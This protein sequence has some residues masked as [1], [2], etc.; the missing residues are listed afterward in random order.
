[1]RGHGLED[2]AVRYP[3]E[4][5]PKC[6]K[7]PPGWGY[8]TPVSPSEG[9]LPPLALPRPGAG[10]GCNRRADLHPLRRLRAGL[11]PGA[12]EAPR[13]SMRRACGAGLLT[14][15]LVRA[16]LYG[17]RDATCASRQQDLRRQGGVFTPGLATQPARRPAPPASA[18]R[19]YPTQTTVAL[20]V[21]VS[22]PH[23]T[24]ARRSCSAWAGCATGAQ[25]C[26]PC[27]GCAPVAVLQSSTRNCTNAS[28]DAPVLQDASPSPGDNRR[29]D[30]HPLRRLRAGLPPDDCHL[31]WSS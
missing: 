12:V 22:H 11:P 23:C 13:S 29:A 5:E 17:L 27:V 8:A 28:G 7:D 6:R 9:L 21:S 31:S 1:M 25:T 3:P 15:P 20:G 2:E 19:R 18:A 16:G 14:A 10:P 30:L 26:T 24:S 4:G